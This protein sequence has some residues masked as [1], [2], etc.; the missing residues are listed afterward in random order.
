MNDVL[1]AVL[2][3]IF[4]LGGSLLGAFLTRTNE[5]KQ[6]LRNEKL[7]AYHEYLSVFGGGHMLGY[8]DIVDVPDPGEEFRTLRI[9]EDTQKLCVR[10]IIISPVQIAEI[11][12]ETLDEVLALLNW[13]DSLVPEIRQKYYTEDMNDD[14]RRVAGERFMA[15]LTEA[16]HSKLTDYVQGSLSRLEQ[17][18][19]LMAEDL[20]VSDKIRGRMRRGSRSPEE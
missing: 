14:E 11:V 17:L 4:A 6:W 7:K 15:E 9:L 18:S 12:Q 3:G 10:V 8:F 13:Y 19:G 5:H 20:G 2:A 16:V 1:I